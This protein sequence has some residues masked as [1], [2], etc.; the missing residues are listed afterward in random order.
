MKVLCLVWE[1]Q[2]DCYF[3]PFSLVDVIG[4]GSGGEVS[5]CS[6]FGVFIAALDF[7]NDVE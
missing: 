4:C 1:C 2:L 3:S 6:D 5:P 7:V